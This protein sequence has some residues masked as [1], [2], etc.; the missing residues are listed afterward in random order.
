ASQPGTHQKIIDMA[1]KAL[2]QS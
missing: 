2:L 1:M